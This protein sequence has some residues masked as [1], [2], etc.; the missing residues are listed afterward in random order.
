M[1]GIS[2]VKLEVSS[3]HLLSNL[4]SSQYDLS[5]DEDE[6]NNLRLDHSVDETLTMSGYVDRSQQNY[7][8]GTT[9]AHTTRNCDGAMQDPPDG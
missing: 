2:I 1:T 4:G 6:K 7:I 8:P 9:Q 5:T 3:T